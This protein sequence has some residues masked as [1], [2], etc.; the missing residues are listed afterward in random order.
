MDVTA[1]AAGSLVNVSDALAS[2]LGTSGTATDT[3]SATTNPNATLT[4]VQL[5]DEDQ[6]YGFTSAEASLNFSIATSAGGGTQGPI[7][8]PGGTYTIAQ[9]RPTG[10]GNASLTCNDSDSTGVVAT[11]ALTVV[12]AASESV[13]CTYSS[14]DS[15]TVTSATINKFLNRR[16]NLILSSEPSNSRR[17]G[18]LNGKVGGSSVVGFAYADLGSLMPVNFDLRTLGSDS[19][20]I[21][22]S[23]SE[24]RAAV[25][26]HALSLD[27]DPN[28]TTR[29]NNPRFDVWFEASYNRFSG[30]QGSTGHFAAGYIGADYLV[31]QDLLVGAM[32]QF[33]DLEDSSSTLNSTVSGS[34]WMFGPYMTA[35]IA[36]NLY[37][38][39]RFSIGKS[40]NQISPFNTYTD[41]FETDRW[42]V[43]ASLTGDMDLGNDWKMQPNAKISYMEETQHAYVDS[44][45]VTIPEQTVSSALGRISP[46]G[47]KGRGA[48]SMS[49]AL[50]LMRFTT[51]AVALEQLLA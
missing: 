40:T 45:A 2:D 7:T 47:L 33:D 10:F 39:G 9:S 24:A 36:P 12:L 4:I 3:L 32:L 16:I 29:V 46:H 37:F 5:S 6:T 44:L 13:T 50:L 11:G 28:A 35:R 34:G 1:N 19:Y 41:T 42:L 31:N 23:L 21:S 48:M 14:V 8:L 15:G 17:I 43:S 20:S 22:G 51:L 38:D 26:R 25:A 27:G 30:S 49:R 18:R